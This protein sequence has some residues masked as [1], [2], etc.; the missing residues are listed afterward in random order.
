MSERTGR[1]EG[2]GRKADHIR[3]VYDSVQDLGARL[4]RLGANLGLA[5]ADPDTL[6]LL[7]AL[8]ELLRQILEKQAIR[9]MDSKK[10]SGDEI[11]RVGLALMRLGREVEE[12]KEQFGIKELNFR[13]GLLGRLLDD[14]R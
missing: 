9:Q 7:L 14:S 8:V 10:L 12:L 5:K 1:V 2:I 4:S 11:E 6:K 3:W 13:L